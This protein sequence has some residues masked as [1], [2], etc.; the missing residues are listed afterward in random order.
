MRVL[1][2]VLLLRLLQAAADAAVAAG[3]GAVVSRPANTRS[4]LP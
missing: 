3:A 2:R 1:L 4:A